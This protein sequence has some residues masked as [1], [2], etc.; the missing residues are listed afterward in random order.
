MPGLNPPIIQTNMPGVFIEKVYIR[1]D[2]NGIV[3]PATTQDGLS[4]D[5]SIYLSADD[6]VEPTDYIEQISSYFGYAAIIF[7]NSKSNSIIS[8]QASVQQHM[9]KYKNWFIP[10]YG[11]IGLDDAL[12]VG[13]TD[14]TTE[15]VSDE[16]SI[17][18]STSTLEV[19]EANYYV[20]T[21]QE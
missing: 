16:E 3:S 8:G 13:S 2:V 6:G 10:G 11:T 18:E 14:I 15:T 19:V 9:K 12:F 21:M 4:I 20:H 7:D 17:D 1:S 5:V